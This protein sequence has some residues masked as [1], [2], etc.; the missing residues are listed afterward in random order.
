MK[1]F[2]SS[3]SPFARKVLVCA[4]ERGLAGRI[5]VVPASVAPNKPNLEL[6]RH[7]PL[8]KVPALQRDDGSALYDSAVICEYLDSLGDAPPLF[9]PSGETR[10][11][12][13]RLH[14]LGDGILD[15]ALLARYE[16]LSRPEALR[17]PEWLD[18]QYAK[19]D[20]ALNYLEGNPAE[21]AG[22]V[23]I[24]TI[25]VG[26]ALGYLDFRFPQMVWRSR[27]PHLAK[28]ADKL[29]KRPSFAQTLPPAA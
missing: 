11:R 8:M 19:I 14:A 24:G 12:V 15:A 28:L 2:Y 17:W 23:D 16:T 7:N 4:R 29:A 21:F 13:L 5:E 18:G 3:A 10:W 26:C 25:T 22:G 1:L 9:P 20:H 6:A 27:H